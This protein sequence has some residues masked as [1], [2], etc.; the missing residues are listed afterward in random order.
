MENASKALTI[1]G[2]V[3]ISMMVVSL[4]V[5]VRVRIS[6]YEKKKAEVQNN[7]QVV[8]FNK[9]LEAYN[10]VISGNKMISLVNLAEELNRQ[11]GSQNKYEDVII[12]ARLQKVGN[13]EIKF[14]KMDELMSKDPDYKNYSKSVTHNDYKYYNMNKYIEYVTTTGKDKMNVLSESSDYFKDF[15]VNFRKQYFKC[16]D[17]QYD[18]THAMVDEMYFDQVKEQK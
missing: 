15:N 11:Y 16:T 2:G 8:E 4:I 12:Y 10:S 13:S 14:Y 5:L 6:S 1:A 3:L 7:A 18:E 17:I 9:K